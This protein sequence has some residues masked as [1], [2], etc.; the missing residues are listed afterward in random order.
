MTQFFAC[1]VQV[2]LCLLIVILELC[3]HINSLEIFV[4]P[5]DSLSFEVSY[6]IIDFVAFSEILQFFSNMLILNLQIF[7]FN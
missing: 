5:F 6:V 7:Q 4:L 1:S 3:I 2:L